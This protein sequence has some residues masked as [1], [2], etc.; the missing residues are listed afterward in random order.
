MRKIVLFLFP[1]LLL[2]NPNPAVVEEDIVKKGVISPIQNFVGTLYFNKVSNIASESS[3]KVESVKFESG[4]TVKSGEVLVQ[5]D[6]KILD[7]KIASANAKLNVVLAELKQ[8]NKDFERFKALFQKK[9]VTEQEYDKSFYLVEKLKAQVEEAR[10]NITEFQIQKNKTN[11]KA[12]FD[13][14]VITKEVEVGEWVNEG[15]II[16]KVVNSQVVDAMFN[17]PEKFISSLDKNKEVKLTI[18]GKNYNGKIYG[19][20]L[21]GDKLT[22]TFPV[23]VKLNLENERIYE[24]MQSTLLL[25]TLKSEE[26]LLVPRDAV[27]KRFEQNVIFTNV[28]G[29]AKM[30]PVEIVGYQDDKVAIKTPILKEGMKVITKGNER[31]FPN[32]PIKSLK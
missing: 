8:A 12:P 28:D 4:D 26:A 14:S 10:A 5:V 13:G 9:S 25:E 3:G 7:S 30:S 22:R 31:I 1:I 19:V 23:K 15:K 27:I 18:N 17:I 29:V 11:I 32:Q 2:A 20:I 21:E 6:D 24:G 16:A